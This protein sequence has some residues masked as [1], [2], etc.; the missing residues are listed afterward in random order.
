MQSPDTGDF[1]FSEDGTVSYCLKCSG[2]ALEDE[3]I[4]VEAVLQSIIDLGPEGHEILIEALSVSW[5]ESTKKLLEE[6]TPITG[7]DTEA[8]ITDMLQVSMSMSIASGLSSALLAIRKYT[9]TLNVLKELDA[10]CGHPECK[11]LREAR[12]N[13]DNN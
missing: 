6:A 9:L 7:G 11:L 5:T 2:G 4:T 12:D 3:K 1:T 13:A 8:I 10:D